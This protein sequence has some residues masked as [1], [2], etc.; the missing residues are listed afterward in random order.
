M[1]SSPSHAAESALL[2]PVP[3]AEPVVASWRT[4][5]DRAALLGVPAHVTVLYPFVD[6]TQLTDHV[7]QRVRA[8]LE[9][10]RPFPFVLSEV[11]WF[12]E[13]VV[14]LA[15]EPDTGFRDLMRLV[16]DEWPE[17][18][19]YGGVHDEVIPHLTLGD[20]DLDG[21]RRAAGAVT[22]HLPIASV[23]TEV[24]LMAGSDLPG[25]WHVRSRFSLR[26]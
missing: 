7:L 10:V 1:S 22:R 21:M 18:P 24:W 20:H 3:E 17:L 16:W 11:R 26:E 2:V 6:A 5:L 12:G 25:S 8:L 14:W 9:T 15:P 19:P 4:E 23:A 13:E